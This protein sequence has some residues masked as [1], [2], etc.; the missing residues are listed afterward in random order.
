M[1]LNFHIKCIHL[2]FLRNVIKTFGITA[3]EVAFAPNIELA[4]RMWG[5]HCGHPMHAVRID[6]LKSIP[7]ADAG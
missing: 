4:V 3:I 1:H 5:H 2:I 6:K 7:H